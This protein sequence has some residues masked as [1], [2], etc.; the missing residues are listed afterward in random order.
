MARTTPARSLG[1]LCLLVPLAL[2]A[3]C[4][5]SDGDPSGP[6]RSQ[7]SDT[8]PGEL[9]ELAAADFYPAVIDAMHEAGTFAF[10]SASSTEGAADSGA[11]IS[12]V[13][14]YGDDGVD[15]R[16]SATGSQPMELLMVDEALYLQG[17]G[18]DLG[19]KSWLRVD[20]RED[21]DSLFGFLAKATD[22]ELAFRATAE[23]RSFQLVGTEDVDGV[24]TNHYAVVM[25][26]AAYTDAL[27]LP[28]FMAEY[29]PPEIGMEM[30]LDGDNRPRRFVQQI[31]QTVPGGSGGAA[32]R[33]AT[34]EGTY[35]D[36]GLDVDIEAPASG[37]VTED[38]AALIGLGG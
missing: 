23:P 31:E 12:G 13:M 22:P 3:G 9:V 29:L 30:W 34:T 38:S 28:T 36:Y 35:S 15:M 24:A 1:A 32:T 16:A 26:T 4:L 6:A 20:L 21:S 25:D 2:L 7:A 17:D 11:T 14:R 8:P 37:D 27:E 18:L 5:G 19:D 33:T 10:T